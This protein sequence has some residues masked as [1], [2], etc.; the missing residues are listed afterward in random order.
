M[1]TTG[2][3]PK[4][5][6]EICEGARIC[7]QCGTSGSELFSS[8]R[9]YQIAYRQKLLLYSLLCLILVNLLGL[10]S[11]ARPESDASAVPLLLSFLIL[12]LLLPALGFS[13]WSWYK[14]SVALGISRTVAVLSS[15]LT[16]FPCISLIALLVLSQRATTQLQRAGVRVGLM[17]ANLR[18]MARD[19]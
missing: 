7:P 13:L 5:G 12:V 6:G 15:I 16:L 10:L 9:L 2:Q 8:G 18:K 19:T 1:A 3:C 14:L 4:C 11:R 17:G